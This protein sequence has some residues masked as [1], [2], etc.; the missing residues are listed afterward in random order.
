CQRN[1]GIVDDE[2]HRFA[3]RHNIWQAS[4]ARDASGELV[5][6]NTA[7]TTPPGADPDRDTPTVTGTADEC[8]SVGGGSRCDKFVHAC[9]MPY[10]QRQIRTTPFYYGPDSDPTLWDSVYQAVDQWDVALRHAVLTAR[11][12]ECLRVSQTGPTQ[13]DAEIA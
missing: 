2:W 11:Y 1:Y 3:S 12:T 10:S 13:S 5:R 7:E 4:H 9:T 8:D 6:C